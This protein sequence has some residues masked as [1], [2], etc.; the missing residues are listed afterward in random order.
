MR[1]NNRQLTGSEF[2]EFYEALRNAFLLEELEQMVSFLRGEPLERIALG[3]SGNAIYHRL[4]ERA[5]AGGWTAELLNAARAER[6]DDP[7]LL[8]FA[9]QFGLAPTI[10]FV[11]ATGESPL[12]LL[13]RQIRKSNRFLN[14]SDWCRRLSDVESRVCRVESATAGALGTGFL[15]GPAA[16]ITSYHVLEDLLEGDVIPSEIRFRFD[17]KLMANGTSL[18]EGVFHRLADDWLLDFSPYSQHDNQNTHASGEPADDELD[19]V[20]VQLAGAAGNE[21]INTGSY[22]ASVQRK[23][24]FIPVP[25]PHPSIQ[26]SGALFILQHPRGGP[27]KLALDT[28][29]VIGFNVRGNRVRYRTNTEPGSSGSPCFDAEW[30]LIALHQG[31]NSSC[32]DLHHGEYNQGIPFH[33]I[34]SLLAS[35]GKS[36][37]VG[38][39][40]T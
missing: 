4:I 21:L 14:V 37:L 9:Q 16:V 38:H 33:Y 34:A 6:P 36:H 27:L 20:L 19:Y 40:E 3:R 35:R 29:A 23:R 30:N 26:P 18:S 5:E 22:S 13:E 39:D 28:D 31:A 25:K 11:A 17:Y 2:R 8:A 32:A 15:V 24:G 12:G 10:E 1:L 7:Q